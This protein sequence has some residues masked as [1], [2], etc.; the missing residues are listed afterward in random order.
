MGTARAGFSAASVRGDVGHVA[1]GQAQDDSSISGVGF[2]VATAHTR[3]RVRQPSVGGDR[4]LP[5]LPTRDDE[6]SWL[7]DAWKSSASVTVPHL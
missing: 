4:G 6:G 2:F 5:L 7:L 1:R 3:D